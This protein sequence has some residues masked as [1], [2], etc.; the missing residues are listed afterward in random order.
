[1]SQP[2][3][4][5]LHP[6]DIAHHPSLEPEIKRAILASWASDACALEAAP[7]LRE[8]PGGARVRFDDILLDEARADRRSLQ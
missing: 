6:F 4:R 7:E 1:M 2:F 5:F 3:S 8:I